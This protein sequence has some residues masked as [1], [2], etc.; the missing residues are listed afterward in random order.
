MHRAP[1]TSFPLTHAFVSLIALQLKGGDYGYWYDALKE[2]TINAYCRCGHCYSFTTSCDEG[3]GP[4]DTGDTIHF[5]TRSMV[6]MHH[7][8][9][10]TLAEFEVPT[11]DNIPYAQEYEHYFDKEYIS[12]LTAQKAKEICEIWVED[13]C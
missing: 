8:S 5:F 1:I 13:A 3:I 12:K 7:N 2:Y 11:R 10:G 6:V 9:D 4:F